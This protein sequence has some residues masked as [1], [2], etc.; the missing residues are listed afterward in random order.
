[1]SPP[2]V[3]RRARPSIVLTV[4]LA[5]FMTMICLI[6]ILA[7]HGPRDGN[8]PAGVVAASLLAFATLAGTIWVWRALRRGSVTIDERGIRQQH[9]FGTQAI[10]WDDVGHYRYHSG[11]M[12]AGAAGGQGG[13]VGV[14]VVAAVQAAAAR[15]R[16][17]H[18]HFTFGALKLYPRAGGKPLVISHK[19][20]NIG[21]VIERAFAALH[22][23][24][25][26]ADFAPFAFDQQALRHAKKGELAFAEIASVQVGNFQISVHKRG[27]RL[28]WA[29]IHM[30]QMNNSMLFLER[31]AALGVVISAANEVFVPAPALSVFAATAARHQ[32]LPQARLHKG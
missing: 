21:E 15:G 25:A 28:S 31:L 20:E 7:T 22:A 16:T 11:K 27:K 10:A 5:I 6:I 24:L 9:L 19:Y 2:L 8:R 14:L 30:G 12:N 17:P 4:C 23:R 32:A 3:V 29:S 26:P 13:L 1:M 18:R